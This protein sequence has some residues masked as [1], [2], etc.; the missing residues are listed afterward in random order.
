MT[1]MHRE[2]TEISSDHA[3]PLQPCWPIEYFRQNLTAHVKCQPITRTR[4]WHGVGL[5]GGCPGGP[6]LAQR[7][8]EDGGEVVAVG[9]LVAARRE[10]LLLERRQWRVGVE[11]GSAVQLACGTQAVPSQDDKGRCC[12]KVCHEQNDKN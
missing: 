3:G 10:A 6:G 5:A 4:R 7:V 1:V 12:V 9:G 2:Q 8:A 11:H